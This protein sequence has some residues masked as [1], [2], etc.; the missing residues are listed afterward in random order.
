MIPHQFSV[1]LSLTFDPYHLDCRF[2]IRKESAIESSAGL[3]AAERT[4]ASDFPF[5]ISF[6]RE[7]N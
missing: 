6:S 5:V 7:Y 1:V 3:N 4:N 2:P